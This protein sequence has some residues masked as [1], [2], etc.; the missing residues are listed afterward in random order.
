MLTALTKSW[1]ICWQLLLRVEIY[2][3]IFLKR[4]EISVDS[5]LLRVEIYVDNFLLRVELY[6]DSFLLRVEISV[7]NFL[8][9]VNSLYISTV[10]CVTK[11]KYIKLIVATIIRSVIDMYNK[12]VSRYET[13]L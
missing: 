1:N 2:V 5:F 11:I 12:R 10:R 9:R 3:D 6:V 8:L 7:D 4:V 13:R